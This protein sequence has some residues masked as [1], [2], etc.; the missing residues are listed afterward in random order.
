MALVTVSE[1]KNYL[2]ITS[3]TH[4]TRLAL[5]AN[6]VSNVISSYCGLLF[7]AADHIEYFD[8]GTN[9][10]FVKNIPINKVYEVSQ[11]SGTSY[12]RL[13][14][15]GSRGQLVDT[16]TSNTHDITLVTDAVLNSR[17]K[18]FG[19]TS[20]SLVS[21]GGVT[22]SP[23]D[24]D[25]VLSSAP[26]CIEGWVRLTAN[27]SIYTVAHLNQDSNN[28]WKLRVDMNGPGLEFVVKTAGSNTISIRENAISNYFPNKWTHVAVNRDDNNQFTIYVN[29]TLANTV[30]SYNTISTDTSTLV[31]GKESDNSYPL[32]GYLDEF[33]LSHTSRYTASFTPATYSFATDEHTKLLLH[34]DGQN[35]DTTTEDASKNVNE[36]TWNPETGKISKDISGSNKEV[37]LFGESK[38]VNSAKGVKVAYNSGYTTIPNDI[39]QAALELIK[40]SY[41]GQDG[42][43]SAQLRGDG[44]NQFRLSGDDF[45]PHVRRILN[46]YR[47]L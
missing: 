1:I 6:T 8:G 20:V 27:S 16:P 7:E 38:F 47:I 25:W 15:A 37:D 33:R 18:K 3:N 41:K 28:N 4:D 5:L 31:L 45:P 9:D 26:F 46:L 43:Q 34:F 39:K 2:V 29:G 42:S 12:V 19:T 10:I 40:I 32:N 44:V 30:T 14:D 35:M 21:G 22:A 36:Y 13:G 11:Y 24:G 17:F 23:S